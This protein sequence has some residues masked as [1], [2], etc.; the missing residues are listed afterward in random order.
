M[1]L[2]DGLIENISMWI[3]NFV[4]CSAKSIVFVC[5]RQR[6]HTAGPAWI[7]MFSQLRTGLHGTTTSLHESIP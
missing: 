5:Y 7:C 6:K 1:Q 3:V 2:L 4:L